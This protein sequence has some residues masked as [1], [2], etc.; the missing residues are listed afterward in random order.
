MDTRSPLGINGLEYPHWPLQKI[1]DLAVALKARFVELT[2]ARVARESVDAVLAAFGPRNLTVEINSPSSEIETGM[3][4]AQRL[5]SPYVIVLDD[6]IERPDWSRAQSIEAFRAKMVE[7]L[8]KPGAE[9]I[10]IA[11][12]NGGFKITRDP[13]DVL[14]IV[15]A[16]DHPRFGVNY[17]PDNYYNAG[18]EG[19]PY[20]YELLKSRIVHVHA[21]N[22]ARYLAD[23]HGDGK[24]VLHRAAGNVVCVPLALGA[25]NWGGIAARLQQDGYEGPVSL[26]PHVL[27]DEMAPGMTADADFLRRL[28]LVV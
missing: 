4:I 5:G 25:V 15:R 19:F 12:E 6:N 3:A 23:V 20:A 18:V 26:E 21:K 10:R 2:P 28:G 11:L 9:G 22:S 27:P 14:A 24:R 1:A 17:D 16:V 7:L 13:D 8:E